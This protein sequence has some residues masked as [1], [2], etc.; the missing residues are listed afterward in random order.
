[1]LL[2]VCLWTFECFTL[3]SSAPCCS[4]ACSASMW[5]ISQCNLVEMAF[6]LI[7]NLCVC[8]SLDGYILYR[9]FFLLCWFVFPIVF[10]M[11]ILTLRLL[12]GSVSSRCTV[13]GGRSGNIS[14]L[15]LRGCNLPAWVQV[16]T[17]FCLGLRW[18]S[19]EKFMFWREFPL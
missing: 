12:T 3:V 7:F 4:W 1:M 2:G 11:Y 13:S 15:L 19:A 16:G 9:L 10:R 14:P 17:C 5:G 8:T 18:S 6:R